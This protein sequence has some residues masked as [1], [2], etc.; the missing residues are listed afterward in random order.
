MS[1]DLS[2]LIHKTRDVYNIVGKTVNVP[3]T[4]YNDSS[5]Q[6]VLASNQSIVTSLTLQT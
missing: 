1:S 4:S 6:N 3:R 5:L 2:E